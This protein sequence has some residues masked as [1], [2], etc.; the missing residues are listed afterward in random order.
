MRYKF[1]ATLS[2]RICKNNGEYPHYPGYLRKTGDCHAHDLGKNTTV[3]SL[4]LH[5]ST[6]QVSLKLPAIHEAPQQSYFRCCLIQIFE[7]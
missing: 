2:L 7:R 6:L 3:G 5:T 4:I 1:T